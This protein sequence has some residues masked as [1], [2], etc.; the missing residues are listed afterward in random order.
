MAKLVDLKNYMKFPLQFDGNGAITSGRNDHIRE[1]IEQVI[2]TLP[3]ERVF[4]PEFGAGAR[5]LIFE[6]NQSALKK[7]TEKRLHSSLTQALQGEVDP[8]SLEVSVE[9]EEEKLIVTISY[10]LATIGQEE[11]HSF[12]L[13]V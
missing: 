4:R 9:T 5:A 11:S 6:P 2:F 12:E 8:K 1:Q 3:G 7:I 13:G 10:T